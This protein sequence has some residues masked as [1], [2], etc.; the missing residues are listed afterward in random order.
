MEFKVREISEKEI[1]KRI[2]GFPLAVKN[3]IEGFLKSKKKRIAL[4]F[5]DIQEKGEDKK[6][7]SLFYKIKKRYPMLK[8]IKDQPRLILIKEVE[9]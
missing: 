8:V 6:L 9:K 4:E 3:T 2:V 1:P 5:D 7:K